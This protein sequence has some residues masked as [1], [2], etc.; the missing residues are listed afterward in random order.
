MA[1]AAP[2]F[3]PLC[4]APDRNP[5]GP[6]TAFPVLSCD[7]HAHIVGPATRFPYVKERIYTPPD[8]TYDDYRRLLSAL[9]VGRA[10]LVQPSVYGADNTAMLDAM[11]R[12]GPGV[13][14]VA[15]AEPSLSEN[16]IEALHAAGVRGLRFNVVDRREDKN[17]V[18]AAMLRD[19][20]RRIAPFG[21]HIELLVNVDEAKDIANAVADIPVPIVLGHL[22]Y[23]KSGAQHWTQHAAFAE[24]LRL[25]AKGRCWIKLTG[26]YRISDSADVPY[27]DVDAAAHALVKAAPERLIWGTDWP[28]VMKKKRMAND[29]E[30]ADLVERWIPDARTRSRVLVD[31]P[32]ELYGFAPDERIR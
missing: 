10:V 13:R 7:T 23:P 18:P 16:E 11:R 27:E 24:M 17:V 6:R 14:A 3:A 1:E 15:V 2:D 22:G 12:F 31:N 4:A 29:G 8:S 28:H 25:I 32:A 9:G 5:R 19:I 21:W 20:A 26:P 30:L